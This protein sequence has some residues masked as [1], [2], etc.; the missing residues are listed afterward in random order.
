MIKSKLFFQFY[1]T[2][3]QATSLG[4]DKHSYKKSGYKKVKIF[5]YEDR[6]NIVKCTNQLCKFIER[7]YPE[8]KLI[9]DINSKQI[10]EFFVYKGQSCSKNTMRNYK[11]CIRKLEKMVKQYLYLNVRYIEADLKI[12]SITEYIRD[13]EMSTKDINIILNECKKSKSEA[14]LGIELSI[15]FGL[16]VA[17]ICKIKGRDIN[18]DKMYIHIH[19][20]KGKRSRDIKIDNLE[21]LE[22]CT[23]IKKEISDEE[24][25]CKLKEDSVNAVIRRMLFKNKITRYIK[26]KT[27]NHA[28]RKAYAKRTYLSNLDKISDEEKAWDSTAADLGHGEGRTVL[29][30]VYVK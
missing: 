5:S 25:I 27:S 23:R 29:K 26:A 3:A 16:R 21:K 2:I 20:S 1:K 6:R 14:R 24:R 9:R 18:L 28:I 10:E 19:E 22:I 15:H 17:E 12:N 4:T 11:Y 7:Q 13:L 30:N 8:I